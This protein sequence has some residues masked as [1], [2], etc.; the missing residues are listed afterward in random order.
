MSCYETFE[1]L[2]FLLI[3]AKDLCSLFLAKME[4]YKKF[5]PEDHG[6]ESSFKLTSYTKLKGWGCKVPQQVSLEDFSMHMPQNLCFLKYDW[7][8]VNQIRW[9]WGFRS[10]KL[11]MLSQVGLTPFCQG[12]N[13]I[14]NMG[15]NFHITL[16]VSPKVLWRRIGWPISAQCCISYRNQSFHLQCRSDMTGWNGLTHASTYILWKYLA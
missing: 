14:R 11:S 7:S 5:R 3:S 9:N 8:H 4:N 16:L 2:K 15:Q 1:F 13:L 12:L 6:L 10:D